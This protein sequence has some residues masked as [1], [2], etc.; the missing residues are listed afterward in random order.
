MTNACIM[1]VG[2]GVGDHQLFVVDITAASFIG[3]HPPTIGRLAVRKLNTRIEG[4]AEDYNAYLGKNIGRH[5]LME[6]FL[7]Y[8]SQGYLQ[9][10]EKSWI[11]LT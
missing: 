9:T 4:C 8:I 6:K 5:R 3:E 10:K 7:Q 2:Y 1:P 11:Q